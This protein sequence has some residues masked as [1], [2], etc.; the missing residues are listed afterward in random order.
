VPA[1]LD[2]LMRG[3]PGRAG[4]VMKALLGMKKLDVEAL[5]R[6]ASGP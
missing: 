4:R 5:R 2:Q 3:E 6:A 1:E